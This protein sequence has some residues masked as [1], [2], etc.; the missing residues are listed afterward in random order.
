MVSPHGRRR[1]ADALPGDISLDAPPR[2]R[3]NADEHKPPNYH[4]LDALLIFAGLSLRV[5]L[6]ALVC[7]GTAFCHDESF[8]SS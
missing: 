4:L 2:R 6:L 1:L 8:F 7:A 5:E 3:Q